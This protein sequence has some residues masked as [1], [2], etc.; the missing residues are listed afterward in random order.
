MTLLMQHR[1]TQ[2]CLESYLDTGTYKYRSSYKENYNSLSVVSCRKRP[3]WQ[4]VNIEYIFP[5]DHIA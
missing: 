1:V 5:Q 3:I 4:I 2:S